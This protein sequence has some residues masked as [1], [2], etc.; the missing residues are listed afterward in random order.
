[1]RRFWRNA[2]VIWRGDGGR[3]AEGILDYYWDLIEMAG[4]PERWRAELD[5]DSISAELIEKSPTFQAE[6]SGG[7]ASSQ[8]GGTGDLYFLSPPIFVSLKYQHIFS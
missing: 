7:P 3:A 2:R 1:M 4:S 5:L 8:I 6:S